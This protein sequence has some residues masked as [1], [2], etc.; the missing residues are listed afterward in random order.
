MP[1]NIAATP[2][3][4]I[5]TFVKV[6]FFAATLC[7]SFDKGL[8]SGTLSFLSIYVPTALLGTK[9]TFG[10]PRYQGNVREIL[11]FMEGYH[12]QNNRVGLGKP[13]VNISRTFP[14]PPNLIN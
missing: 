1:P 9:G 4:N 3:I 13:N 10:V 11:T 2:T 5:I 12:L 6:H 14:M 7:S 8:N